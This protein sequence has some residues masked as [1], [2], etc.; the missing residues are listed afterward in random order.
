[1]TGEKVKHFVIYSCAAEA[2]AAGFQQRTPGK[3]AQAS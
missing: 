3:K 2:V 1:V